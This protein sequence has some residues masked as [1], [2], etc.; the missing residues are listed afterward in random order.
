MMIEK[1]TGPGKYFR[2]GISLVELTEMFPDEASAVR[3]FESIQ[4]PDGRHCAHC[5]GLKTKKV[6][7][8]KPMPYW[9][10]D[11]R[12][13]FSVRTGTALQNSRLPL[14]K[15]A[16]AIY[17]FV[18]NL[19]G[20]SSMRLHRELNV[21]QKTAWHMLHRLRE[22]WTESGLDVFTGPAEV[23]ETYMGGREKNKH[24]SKKQKAGRGAI[25]KTAIVGMKDRTSGK[26]VAQSVENTR[27]DTLQN[28]IKQHTKEDAIIYTDEAKAYMGMARKHS[29]IKHSVGE[30]VRGMVHTNGI[31]SFW[32]MLKR[33]HKGTYHKMSPKHLDRYVTEFAGRHN[34][35]PA[36]TVDQMRNVVANLTGKQLMYKDLIAD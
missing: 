11:C 24:S 8:A 13:Y 36:D 34:V 32:S 31:E 17:L 18:T 20:I 14:R 4:W 26:I 30:Y 6:K 7:K 5:G 21:T 22:A 29:A 1:G 16:F 25:G 27:S 15:W 35:R 10:P 9:C 23:D 33:A 28:F 3:W 19:K 2:K 12:S